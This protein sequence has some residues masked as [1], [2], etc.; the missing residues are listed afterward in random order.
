MSASSIERSG[1]LPM[2]TRWK[3]SIGLWGAPERIMLHLCWRDILMIA[4]FF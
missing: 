2:N 3:Q 1:D 4:L